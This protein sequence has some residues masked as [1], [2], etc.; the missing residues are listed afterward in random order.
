MGLIVSSGRELEV[1]RR[2][3]SGGNW[4]LVVRTVA[5]VVLMDVRGASIVVRLE[6]EL[7]RCIVDC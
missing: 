2:S 3:R 1:L 5:E 4:E 6:R 7:F